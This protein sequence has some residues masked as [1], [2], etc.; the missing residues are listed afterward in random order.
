MDDP[1]APWPRASRGRPRDPR[2][3]A[4]VVNATLDL[5]DE[6]GYGALS[7]E[8]V[9]RRARVSKP[10]IYRRWSTKA[11]LVVDTL[12]I[13]AGT[14]PAPD[15]GDLRDD[16]AAVVLHMAAL[17][18]TP[19]AH[20]VV[21]SLL[22]DLANQPELAH[23]FRERYIT[24]RRASVHRALD[25]AVSRGEIPPLTDHELVCDLLAGP[26]FHAA[27]LLDQDPDDRYA[28]ETVDAVMA[29]LHGRQARPFDHRSRTH[30]KEVP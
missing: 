3:S 20:K 10:S 12:T 7:L 30:Q 11:E 8:M 26:L 5:L 22:G 29:V 18:R 14:D 17:Y 24:P 4:S 23:R 13:V 28:M 25:R 6:V 9:A 19:L 2:I 1:T 27:F 16:L 21:P 15:T